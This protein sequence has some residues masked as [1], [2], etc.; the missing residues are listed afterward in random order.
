[1]RSIT[2]QAVRKMLSTNSALDT[3]DRT[4]DITPY[5]AQEIIIGKSGVD[6]GAFMVG[7]RPMDAGLIAKM[8]DGLKDKA[9]KANPKANPSEIEQNK[10]AMLRKMYK[11]WKELKPT[12]KKYEGGKT[13]SAFYQYVQDQL[14]KK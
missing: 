11:D 1:M 6:S 7:N 9:Y 14:N 3:K 10:A 13:T 2:A 12:D 5:L 8:D 4:S